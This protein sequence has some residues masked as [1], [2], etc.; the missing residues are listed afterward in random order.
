QCF[1][2]NS[3]QFI[4]NAGNDYGATY[5]WTF[6]DGNPATSTDTT[7]VV[8]FLSPG[9]KLVTLTVTANGCTAQHSAT[10]MVYPEPTVTAGADTSFCEGDGGVGLSA[11]VSDG[12]APYYYTWGCTGLLGACGIDSLFD[13]D[14]NVNPTQTGMY[15]VQVTDANGCT[16]NV[17]SVLVTV[18]PKPTVN[19]GPDLMLCG[20]NAPCEVLMPSVNGQGPFSFEWF[21]ATGLNDSSLFNPCAR[22]DTTTI[23]VLVATEISTGCASNHSTLD[24]ASSV[25]VHVN[26]VPVADAGPNVSICPFDTAV[27]QG[28][29]SAAGPAYQFQW[30]PT[31]SLDFSNIASPNASPALTTTYSLVVWSNGC[32]SLAD[33]VRVEV[34]TIPSV[35][36]GWDREVCLG[37]STLLDAS[38]SGDST[39]QYSFQWS[40]SIGLD[41]PNL[42]D[43]IAT[44]PR[45]T[46]YFVIATSNWGCSSTADSVTVTLRP[47][48]I[49]DAGL[50]TTICF[51]H[52]LHLDG[53]YYYGPTDSVPN[54]SQIQYAWTPAALLGDS[55]LAQPYLLP[56]VSGMYYLG[57][58][59]QTCHTVDSVLVLVIPELGAGIVADT[60][61]ICNGDSLTL[62]ALGGFGNANYQWSPP[63]AFDDPNAQQ[64]MA[65]LQDTT[66]VGLILSE[67]GCSDTVTL[68]VAV[69]PSPEAAFL[70]SPA[71]GCAPL[72]LSVLE[73]SSQAQAYL[74]NFGDGSP[75]SNLP[76][77]TH[78][79]DQPG[80]YSLHFT[81]L[82][83]GACFSEAPSLTV[84]VLEPPLPVVQAQPDYPAVLYLPEAAIALQ[85][86][87]PDVAS[88]SWDF[89]DGV[90]G[91]GRSVDHVYSE[92]GYYFVIVHA[93][94]AAGCMVRDTL[95][96][97][98]VRLP[99][100][101]VP[102][103]FSPNGDGV[104]DVFLVNYNGDQP[105]GLTI[106]D[107]WGARAYQGNRKTMGWDGLVNGQ[108]AP[109]GVYYYH[110]RIG[111][112][113]YSGELS[114]LR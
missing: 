61:V 68:E 104:N 44:P 85:E 32:P 51:G 48:P 69:I 103:V 53:S 41:D 10:V 63:L 39:A 47:T 112:K 8:T 71:S 46:T 23:Y 109:D 80:I 49:A 72:S 98:E 77:T 107:R 3:H 70:H 55:T 37:E 108:L 4:A 87:N 26:P 43:P 56:Q 27:L 29:G 52:G 57:V 11:N 36:A 25:V 88:S 60:T 13:N 16:S 34:H 78:T 42:E 105:F 91:S 9:P 2:G 82:H 24:T 59:H 64:P 111:E 28:T 22:P 74:W 96:P 89:G 15:F 1:N 35:D 50:D 75:V 38:A 101:F 94:N 17:D 81:A 83:E 73:N 12:T 65:Y 21:P 106:L 66:T 30:S 114:L 14:P 84:T 67:S 18:N 93:G 33:T 90:R 45:S 97:Y 113:E 62:Q 79:Y 58:T 19:A 92:P 6:Q 86:L 102:N 7:V 95:G 40:T 54:P 100:L 110:L 99:D 76:A 5:S 20:L 31:T